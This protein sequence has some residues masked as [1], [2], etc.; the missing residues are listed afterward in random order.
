MGRLTLTLHHWTVEDYDRVISAGVLDK[1]DRVEQIEGRSS[2]RRRS[3]HFTRP[4]STR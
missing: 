1:D 4:P 3:V 2:R